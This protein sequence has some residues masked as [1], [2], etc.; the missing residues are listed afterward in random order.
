MA[1]TVLGIYIFSRHGDRTSKS[2][3]PSNL[4]NL[5]QQQISLSATYYR[6]AYIASN[7]PMK[8]SGVNADVVKQSQINV[9]APEDTVLFN[10]ALGFTQ[11]LYPPL[12]LRINAQE[13]RNGTTIDPPINGVQYIPVY[14]DDTTS[15]GQEDAAW[16]QGGTSCAKAKI[17]SNNYFLSSE[18]MSLL[19]STQGFYD[20]LAPVVNT[21][22]KSSEISFKNAYTVW[23]EINVALIHNKTIPSVDVLTPEVVERAASLAAQHEWGLAWNTSDTIRAISGATLAAQMIKH[24]NATITGQGKSKVSVQFGPYATFQ[25]F[26]GLAQLPEASSIFMNIPDYA[27]TM[28]FELVTNASA[29]PFPDPKDI[30]VRFKFHNGTITSNTTGPTAYR[31]F[32][33]SEVVLPWMLFQDS[34][35]KIA[36]GDQA[37]WCKACGNSTGIC[38][39]SSSATHS[40]AASSKGSENR[41]S[42][43]QGGVIGAFVTLAVLLG[44]S[45]LFLL[46]GGYRIVKKGAVVRSSSSESSGSPSRVGKTDA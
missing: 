36:I 5:G 6:N 38:A 40:I 17:S 46:L 37:D 15:A 16:L 25:S 4:T 21:T 45:G 41:I 32:G 20:M 27:S 8:I 42:V 24:L 18:Y 7:A 13:L 3:P 29:S 1:E 11:N 12:G 43:A 34:M 35:K 44:L 22:F 33:Q 2:H 28:V 39:S 10:S 9:E 26:F 14:T 19:T 23:D 30:S 31:L